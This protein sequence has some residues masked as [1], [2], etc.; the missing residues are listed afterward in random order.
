LSEELRRL[1]QASSDSSK[2]DSGILS[3]FFSQ[4]CFLSA[5]N[6]HILQTIYIWYK[7]QHVACAIMH[8][9]E[10]NTT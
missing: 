7:V 3:M 4:W 1:K 10:F 8:F 9:L 5:S 6:R 2:K